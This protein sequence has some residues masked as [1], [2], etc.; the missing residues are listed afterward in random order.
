MAALEAHD[1]VAGYHRGRTRTP[2]LDVA[3]LA[4]PAGQLVAVIGPNG[5]G[6]STLLRTLIGAQ[7]PLAAWC[8]STAPRSP[9]STG[10]NGPAASPWC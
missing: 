3:S 2:V 8:A 5:G 10:A 4:A 9:T 6:K 7:P 1:L